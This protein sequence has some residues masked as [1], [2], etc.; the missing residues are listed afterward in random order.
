M[1]KINL[2]PLLDYIDPA[3][4][5]YQEWLQV[6]MGLKEEGYDISDWES[7]SAKDIT[8]YHAGECAKKWATFTGHYNGSPVTGATIVNMAKENGWTATPHLP[9]RAYGWD[10]EIIAD[11]EVII[12]KNWVEEREIE[13]PGDDWNPAK[14]LITYLELLYDSSDYVGYVTESWEQDG[15]F[16]PSKGKFKRT[17]GELIHALSECDGDIGAVLGDYNPDVGAWIRFNPLD[18]RGVRN[19]NVTEF[20]YALVESDCMP[21]DKQNEIIRKLEL[22]VTCMVYSGGK[23]VHAIVKIDAANYDE[24]RKRVDYLYN[25]CRKNGLEIDVQNRNPSRLSRMPGVTR[26]D[27]K[28]FLVDTNIG[29]SSFAEWQT[30]IESINDNLP[31]P[32]SLRD[33]WNNL[34][35]LA[36]PLIENVLRKGHKMLLAGP[37]KAGKSFALIELVIAIAEGRK[38]LNWDCSQ[39]RV[40]Y[41]NLELDAASCLHRFKD[42]YTELGWEARSLSNIDIWNLRGKSLPMDKLAPKLI[43]RAVKQEYTAIIIDPIYKVIT[44][45]E[46]SAEQM[47]HFCNQFDRIATELNCSVIYCHHHSKGAQGGKRAIDRASGSG[48][49]GRDADALLDMIELDA[50]QVGSSRSAWRI[51]GTLREYASFRPVNVWFDYPVHRID[52]TGT[53]ETIKLDVEMKLNEKGQRTRQKQ[54]QSRIQNLETAYNACLISDEVTID[55]MS[56]YLDVSPKTL[57]RDINSSEE[58]TVKNGK[59]ERNIDE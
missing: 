11:E 8:R 37:S 57:R 59:V 24:Y 36:P 3:F 34:P 13:D 17:A 26:K 25:I 55:D 9:D 45:D 28:Q 14:D 58:F 5:D 4:C 39:G 12:D 22:P 6:G 23:S 52:D 20:K 29:K 43:R 15:K 30:W 44:G 33:F 10:D 51:E 54:R 49:F 2:I 47:A 50:E 40:L 27:K 1:R 41:V 31:E 46:N 32:E 42:V 38:W 53:L 18:G 7:W 16:L 48:V 56:E 19:E 21:I 35:P